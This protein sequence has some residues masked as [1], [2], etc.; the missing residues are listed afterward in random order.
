MNELKAEIHL[1]QQ[2]AARLTDAA[3][4]MKAAEMLASLERALA[5]LEVRLSSTRPGRA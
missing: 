1:Q 5:A 4:S 2:R 3:E